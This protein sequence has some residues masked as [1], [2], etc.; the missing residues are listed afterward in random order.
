MRGQ[1]FQKAQ[2]DP[3]T[4]KHKR[5]S[6]AKVEKTMGG[7][8][9]NPKN[10][11]RTMSFPCKGSAILNREIEREGESTRKRVRKRFC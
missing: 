8:E 2:Y 7:L 11:F 5:A 3:P 6:L 1:K 9:Q 4:I 10:I